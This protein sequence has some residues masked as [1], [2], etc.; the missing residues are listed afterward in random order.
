MARCS[1]WKSTRVARSRNSSTIERSLSS[2]VDPTACQSTGVPS[3]IARARSLTLRSPASTLHFLG[4]AHEGTLRRLA[5]RIRGRFVQHRSQ[6]FIAVA[7][8]DA[9]DDRLPLLGLQS[10]ERLLVD[11]HG[12]A[13]DRVFKWRLT[14]FHID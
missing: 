13:A 9:G 14:G 10:L 2:A 4:E 6:L 12:F 5:G 8:L 1:R 3:R 7:Q 11:L